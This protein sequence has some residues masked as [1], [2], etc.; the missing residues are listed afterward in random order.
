MQQLRRGLLGFLLVLIGSAALIMPA[1]STRA[2]EPAVFR[3]YNIVRYVGDIS[4]SGADKLAAVLNDGDTI[5]IYSWGGIASAG[6]EIAHVIRQYH[7]SIRVDGVCA[8]GC[9]QYVFLSAYD[10][11]I[12]RGSLL[13]FHGSSLIWTRM[14]TLRPDLFSAPA[15]AKFLETAR[16]E[17]ELLRQDGI[18]P[19]MP[20]CF[21]HALGPH[22]DKVRRATVLGQPDGLHIPTDH[23]AVRP[24]LA[25]LR[26]L[27]VTRV[28]E[29][30][31]PTGPEA[32]QADPDI[33]KGLDIV[34]LDG[35]PGARSATPSPSGLSGSP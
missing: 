27:G 16:R 3:E 20:A 28:T 7:A 1:G 2:A 22:F 35:C 30:E 9:A 18:S 31:E 14:M 15:A 12:T 24:S 29:V 34:D 6:I 26:K 11:K 13:A 33:A 32:R 8:S 4:A 5:V 17:R 23:D 21:D 25:L 10:K 19:D